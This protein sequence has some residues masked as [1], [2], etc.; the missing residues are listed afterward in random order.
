MRALAQP[1]SLRRYYPLNKIYEKDNFSIRHLVFY[2]SRI[3]PC[4]SNGAKKKLMT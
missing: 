3:T 1:A 4:R 2:S